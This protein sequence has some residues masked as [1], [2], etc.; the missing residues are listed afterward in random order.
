MKCLVLLSY[1]ASFA[2]ACGSPASNTGVNRAAAVN[3]NANATAYSRSENAYTF[4]QV[5][6]FT[7]ELTPSGKEAREIVGKTVTESK[8]WQ[9]KAFDRE[10]RKLMGPDYATMKKFWNTET[11]IRKFGDFLMMTGCEQQ[12]CIDNQYVIFIDLGDGRINVIH[13]SKDAVKEWH[14][15]REIQYL[16]PPFEEEL[17]RMKA[18]E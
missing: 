15:Y 4:A 2:I 18:R 11:P 7:Y 1:C 17:K 8:L 13:I 6:T 10:L 16:P 14:A 5:S 3:T 12:N 9:N